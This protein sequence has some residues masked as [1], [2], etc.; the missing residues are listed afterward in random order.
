[1]PPHPSGD[2]SI[3][4]FIRLVASVIR[5][6]GRRLSPLFQDVA[7]GVQPRS[8][9]RQKGEQNDTGKWSRKFSSLVSS[10][11]LA[12]VN[13]CARHIRLPVVGRNIISLTYC[14]RSSWCRIDRMF[15]TER[16]FSSDGFAWRR[17]ST[18]CALDIYI[19]YME[20]MMQPLCMWAE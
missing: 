16:T 15:V 17:L 8:I 5:L 10:A 9:C 3:L 18:A 2:D 20:G 11:P 12:N 1:M 14:H 6:F 13:A 7:R 4:W 19:V